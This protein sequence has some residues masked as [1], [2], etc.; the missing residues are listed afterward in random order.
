MFTHIAST[1]RVHRINR[2]PI[3]RITNNSIAFRRGDLVSALRVATL[4]DSKSHVYST[5]IT[6]FSR[7]G[8]KE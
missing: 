1:L 4:S 2:D 5:L 7:Q 3:F 8:K 6:A